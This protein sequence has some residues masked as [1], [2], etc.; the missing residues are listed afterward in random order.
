[1]P[2]KV[3]RQALTPEVRESSTST[4]LLLCLAL[5]ILSIAKAGQFLSR[6]A[7]IA[8]QT[9]CPLQRVFERTVQDIFLKHVASI[10]RIFFKKPKNTGMIGSLVGDDLVSNNTGC[11]ASQ[12]TSDGV[13]AYVPQLGKFRWGEMLFFESLVVV[14]FWH[15]RSSYGGTAFRGDLRGA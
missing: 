14:C 6:L 13:R 15:R 5:R 1:M 2:P 9:V 12:Y 4:A 11:L 3:P 10:L 8:I 7:N